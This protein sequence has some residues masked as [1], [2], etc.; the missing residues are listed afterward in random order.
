MKRLNNAFGIAILLIAVSLFLTSGVQAQCQSNTQARP[1]YFLNPGSVADPIDCPDCLPDYDIDLHE[2]ISLLEGNV[3]YTLAPAIIGD[4]CFD[5]FCHGA[6]VE[7]YYVIIGSS[8]QRFAIS[9]LPRGYTS[10]H[11]SL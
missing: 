9:E 2:Y 6:D 5:E 3:P 10:S 7:D 4:N 1:I 11:S 8:P